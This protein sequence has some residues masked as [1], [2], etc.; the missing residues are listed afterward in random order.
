MKTWFAILHDTGEVIAEEKTYREAS[1][2]AM[3][4][5]PWGNNPKG[6]AAPYYLTT[7]EPAECSNCNGSGKV[8][9]G[10]EDWRCGHCEG[11]GYSMTPNAEFTG[12]G[13]VE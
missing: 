2:E 9:D 6:E 11:T 1:D 7:I 12:S 8:S 5:C 10:H 4:E 13:P 3:K